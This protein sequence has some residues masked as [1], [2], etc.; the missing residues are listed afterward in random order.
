M[1]FD[2]SQSIDQ[3]DTPPPGPEDHHSLNAELTSGPGELLKP[4]WP[5]THIRTPHQLGELVKKLSR[6]EEFGLDTETWGPKV[7]SDMLCLIQISIP[8][9]AR[10]DRAADA[11]GRTYLIDVVALQDAVTAA[12]SSANPLKPLQAALEDPSKIKIIHHAQFERA[13]FEKYG[14]ELAGVSDTKVAAKRARPDLVSYSLQACVYEILGAEMSKAEQT[15]RWNQR[16]LSPAQIDYAALDSEIVVRLDRKLRALERETSP[17]PTWSIDTTLQRL[18]EARNELHTILDEGETGRTL[19]ALAQRSDAG[20]AILAELLRLEGASGTSANYRGAYG[21]AAQRRHPIEA[22][23]LAQLRALVPGVEAAVVR[24][25]TSK[26]AIEAALDELGRAG[27]LDAIWSAVNVLTGERTPPRLTIRLAAEPS[28]SG[29][30]ELLPPSGLAADMPKESL[31]RAVLEADLGRLRTIQRLGLGDRVAI[32]EGRIARYSERILEL[33]ESTSP[34]GSR[35]RHEGPF[36]TAEFTTRPNRAIDLELLKS[37]YPDVADR[38]IDTTATKGRLTAALRAIG[39]DPSTVAKLT[40][41][42]FPPTG[43]FGPPRITIRPNYALF[44]KGLE[45]DPEME[46]PDMDNEDD[47]L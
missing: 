1:L 41:A 26:K 38:C 25:S 21:T 16:P 32:L 28:P 47:L 23:D 37:H 19:R 15:S 12:H 17:D 39:A 18:S 36:G 24:E 9:S 7:L 31:M 42:I 20:R 46:A 22:F 3:S 6:A 34:D 2:R 13:Q 45:L 27:E 30:N 35:A 8:Q 14:I 10:S 40:Q 43:D 11:T 29:P 4:R 44:Y 5:I 33:L